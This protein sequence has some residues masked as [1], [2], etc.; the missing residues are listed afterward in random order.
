MIVQSC[1]TDLF[2][3]PLSLFPWFTRDDPRA[4]SNW[5]PRGL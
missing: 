5:I 1:I 3:P 2:P 4:T